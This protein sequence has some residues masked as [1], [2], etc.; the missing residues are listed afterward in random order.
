MSGLDSEPPLLAQPYPHQSQVLV[1]DRLTPETDIPDCSVYNF[2]I[3][4]PQTFILTR[5]SYPTWSLLGKTTLTRMVCS[6]WKGR[7]RRRRRGFLGEGSSLHA[8][9]KHQGG[10]RCADTKLRKEKAAKA[11]HK[12]RRIADMFRPRIPLL[13][14]SNPLSQ[15]SPIAE[16]S[17]SSNASTKLPLPAQLHRDD[18]NVENL[19]DIPPIATDTASTTPESCSTSQMVTISALV[20]AGLCPGIQLDFPTPAFRKY[21]WQLHSFRNMSYSIEYLGQSGELYVRSKKCHRMPRHKGNPCTEC[22]SLNTSANVE[23]MRKRA[24]G[25]LPISTNFQFYLYD[26]AVDALTR[27]SNEKNELKLKVMLCTLLLRVGLLMFLTPQTLCYDA[28]YFFNLHTFITHHYCLHHTPYSSN[29]HC[30]LADSTM[31]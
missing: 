3:S 24:S 17:T 15:S 27:K 10:S 12:Q 5:L 22:S 9:H 6:R 28:F 2:T 19:D 13:S 21:P 11:A 23:R 18:F 30:G 29:R 1:T 14:P 20:E 16:L 8:Y 25:P 4:A 26:H 7:L 31:L